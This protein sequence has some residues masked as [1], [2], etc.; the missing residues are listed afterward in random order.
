MMHRVKSTLSIFDLIWL[1]LAFVILIAVDLYSKSLWLYILGV[2]ILFI[3]ADVLFTGVLHQ[4]ETEEERK[5]VLKPLSKKLGLY[6]SKHTIYSRSTGSIFMEIFIAIIIT[7]F[8][9]DFLSPIFS[10]SGV[11]AHKG[12]NYI[13]FSFTAIVVFVVY[14]YT[15]R[16]RLTE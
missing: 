7:S 9:T 2:S 12:I 14:L 10:K 5:K 15:I 16:E 6:I 11:F 3:I 8:V 13:D 4:T 1:I